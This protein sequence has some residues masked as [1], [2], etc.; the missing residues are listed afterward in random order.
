MTLPE[1]EKTWVLLDNDYKDVKD[2]E[3]IVKY[4]IKECVDDFEYTYE[5]ASGRKHKIKLR[6]KP[7]QTIEV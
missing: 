5:D 4:R 7:H 2:K 3:G 6:E 1:A